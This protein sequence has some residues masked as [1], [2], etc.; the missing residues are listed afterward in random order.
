[1]SRG[2]DP[3]AKRTQGALQGP[4]NRGGRPGGAIDER[5][6]CTTDGAHYARLLRSLGAAMGPFLECKKA[7]S[8]SW[9]RDW[10]AAKVRGGLRSATSLV[11]VEPGGGLRKA[12]TVGGHPMRVYPEP[13]KTVE[14]FRYCD[15]LRLTRSIKAVRTRRGSDADYVVGDHYRGRVRVRGFDGKTYWHSICVPKGYKTDL[16]SVPRWGRVVVGRAGPYLEACIFHDWLY[17]AWVVLRQQPQWSMKEFADDVV[18]VAMEAAKVGWRA[19]VINR[20]VRMGG[21]EEFRKAR[22]GPIEIPEIEEIIELPGAG[23]ERDR[24]VAYFEGVY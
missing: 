12:T 10:V 13:Y 24:A 6:W 20:A 14:D 1:M 23:P 8:A 2:S 7:A 4:G 5:L 3:A 17:E 22:R 18:K 19:R 15:D 9:T 21:G 16:V 11:V